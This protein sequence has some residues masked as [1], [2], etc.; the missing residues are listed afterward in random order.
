MDGTP[1]FKSTSNTVSFTSSPKLGKNNYGSHFTGDIAEV[2]IYDHALSDADRQAVSSYLTVKY[3]LQSTPSAPASA[4][5][6]CLA[7]GQALISW[8]LSAIPN[9]LAEYTIARKEAGGSFSAIATVRDAC[10]YIDS[11]VDPETEYFYKVSASNWAGS[12]G[13]SSEATLVDSGAGQATF[14]TSGL[15]LWLRADAV[16][17]TPLR[18]WQDLSGVGNDAVQTASGN[19]PPVVLNVQNGKPVVRFTASSSQHFPLPNLM[20]GAMAGEVVAVLKSSATSVGV[21]HF[22]NSAYGTS[23]PW[24]TGVNDDFGRASEFAQEW[25]VQSLTNLHI[26]NVSSSSGL[27]RSWVNGVPFY[28]S[29]SNTVA[30]TSSPKLGKNNNGSHFTGD[31]AEVLIYNR[32]LSDSERTAVNTYLNQKYA[33]V[34][35]PS[36][37]TGLRVAALNQSTNSI[38]WNTELLSSDIDYNVWRSEDDVTWTSIGSVRNSGTFFDVVPEVGI[39]YLYAVQAVNGSGASSFTSAL[40]AKRNLPIVGDFPSSGLRLWLAA[41]AAITTPLRYW[42]DLSGIGNDAMQTTSGNRPTVV[43]NVLGGKPVV[44]FLASSSQ[45]FPLPNLMSGATAGEV[46]AVL[47]SSAT[48]VGLWHFGSSAYGASYPWTNG[49]NEDFGRSSEFTQ[50]WPSRSLTDFRIYSVSSSAG[51]WQSWID[52]APFFKSSSNT[53]AFTSSPKL[54]KN[55][56]GSHFTGDIA[57]VIMYNRPL[58]ESERRT[59]RQYLAIKYLLPDFDPDEDG[60]KTADEIIAGTDPLNSD[61]NADGLADGVSIALGIDPLSSDSDDD[62]LTNAEELALGTNPLVA[63]TDRDGVADDVD[64]YPL[65]PTRSAAPSSSS[66]SPVIT[67]TF[68]AGLT[69]LP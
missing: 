22:G 19:Q 69:L 3:A 5:A 51:W 16:T 53:V 48:G 40:A 59:V 52:G 35:V 11:T 64:Y 55:N 2:L 31:I 26:Y 41:D 36:T 47:K 43:S 18:Y 32:A 54:G 30:F 33:I 12:S 10:S 8:T 9:A 21:W 23:Y 67:L 68:P 45:H 34:T 6:R 56:Y 37:P 1:L 38:T 15:R 29:T 44:R 66:G 4:V 61:T 14:P 27:W 50:G 42:Q 49:V 58:Q 39:D 65:D 57:E 46:V 13:Y 62:G 25:P 17:T 60:L 7:P 28:K 63:D 20:S 24:S